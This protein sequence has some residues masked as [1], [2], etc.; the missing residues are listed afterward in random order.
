M[1]KT[2]NDN[3]NNT[4]LNMEQLT[5]KS[6]IA[7]IEAEK[8][9]LKDENMAIVTIIK[10]A[11][12]R[13]NNTEEIKPFY[14]TFKDEN[15]WVLTEKTDT[16]G[17][18]ETAIHMECYFKLMAARETPI[19]SYEMITLDVIKDAKAVN[20]FGQFLHN[21]DVDEIATAV[22]ALNQFNDP[23][24]NDLLLNALKV[25]SEDIQ[26]SAVH[27]LLQHKN[28]R[29]I[30]VFISLLKNKSWWVRSNAAWVLGEFGEG[31]AVKPLLSLLLDRDELGKVQVAAIRAL[32]NIGDARAVET[33][34]EFLSSDNFE[35]K[36]V[37]I[38]ALG[39][40]QDPHAS[41]ALKE[42]SL[43]D[44][45]ASIREKAVD[46]LAKIK[47]ERLAV[48]V[49]KNAADREQDIRYL[50]AFALGEMGDRRAIK[51]LIKGLKATS[52]SVQLK[53]TQLLGEMRAYPAVYPLLEAL[54]DPEFPFRALAA[55]ALGQINGRNAEIGIIQTLDSDDDPNV[56][57]AE[58][59]ALGFMK[60]PN[61]SG[62]VVRFLEGP[63]KIA[64]GAAKALCKMVGNKRVLPKLE[65]LLESKDTGVRE[66]VVFALGGIEDEKSISLL[67]KALDDQSAGVRKIAQESLKNLGES[68]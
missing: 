37:A 65:E 12:K 63:F 42:I 28:N 32:G 17:F 50:T 18:L 46:A 2:I 43:R 40:F 53:A 8:K 4:G 14:T 22:D 6:I 68:N 19:D 34:T 30:E 35:L 33:L 52:E 47:G 66:K 59:Q 21:E 55:K 51:T 45:D 54:Q 24:V 26:L 3:Q 15:E 49:E 56:I 13:E 62:E 29:T 10:K 7:E 36:D 41:E 57:L 64:W 67:K 11:L 58:I 60:S 25:D 27:G 48:M 23:R 31:R 16:L 38:S 9:L 20:Y 39:E 1:V 44:N 5:R 61:G